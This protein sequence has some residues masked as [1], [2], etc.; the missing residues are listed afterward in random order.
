[1][2][3]A[4]SRPSWGWHCARPSVERAPRGDVALAPRRPDAEASVRRPGITPL[5]LGV[6][7]LSSKP[8]EM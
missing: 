8:N 6:V 5:E 4:R 3:A 2:A 7:V 1:M